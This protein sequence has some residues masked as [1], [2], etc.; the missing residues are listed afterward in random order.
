MHGVIGGVAPV[1]R[2]DQQD[3]PVR[4]AQARVD[5]ALQLALVVPCGLGEVGAGRERRP[6][7]VV[8]AEIHDP[9]VALV[10]GPLDGEP[11]SDL[12]A[13]I[14]GEGRVDAAGGRTHGIIDQQSGLG[15]FAVAVQDVVAEL[16]GPVVPGFPPCPRIAVAKDEQLADRDVGRAGAG[17]VGTGYDK[18]G[19]PTAPY[20]RKQQHHQ[21]ENPELN[22][23]SIE[24][25]PHEFLPLI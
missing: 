18:A 12:M 9:E 22:P 19:G 1:V 7:E 24:A 8:V 3:A 15:Q 23:K 17:D 13:E 10:E 5:E 25:M 20:L 14:V 11:A 2:H 6:V 21:A 4:A 16:F